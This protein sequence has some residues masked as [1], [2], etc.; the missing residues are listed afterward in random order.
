MKLSTNIPK[1][2]KALTKRVLALGAGIGI[3][4][5]G[6]VMA[7]AA[8][9]QSFNNL[10]DDYATTQVARVGQDYAPSTT[11]N[12]GDTVTVFL[13]DHAT[14]PSADDAH[15]VHLQISLDNGYATSHN[16]LGAVSATN[17]TTASSTAIVNV[18]TTSRITY[19]PDSAKFYRN[20]GGAMTQVN[21]PAGVNPNDIVGA[22]VTVGDQKACWAYA[23]AATIQVH[24]EGGNAAIV[25]NK[26]VELD[27]GQPTFA[28]SA[29]AQPSDVVNFK[30]FLQNTGTA[31]G[32]APYITDT[33]DNR[34]AYIAGSSYTRTKVNNADVDQ[35]YADSNIAING[36]TMTWKFAD[37]LPRPD[38]S[39]YLLFRA[40]VA[41]PAS[42]PVGVTN[43]PNCALSGFTGVSAN[44]NCVN[45][46]VT[47]SADKVVSFSIRKEV[48]N[49]TKG[50]GQWFNAGH[51]GVAA[52]GD[53]LGYRLIVINTGNTPA[54]NVT[55]KDILPAGIAFA[56]NMKT[57]DQDHTSGVD[58]A[59]SDLVNNGYVYST[60]TNGTSE[61]KSI[62][63]TGKVADVCNGDQ[64]LKNV[65]QVIYNGQVQ[66]QDFASVN[67]SCSHSLVI[68]KEIQDPATHEWKKDIGTVHEG[69]IL[70]YRIQ[71]QNNGNATTTN[72]IVR[73]VLPQQVAFVNNS[74]SIDG[75]F[76][77]DQNVQNAFMHDGMLITNLKP[78]GGKLMMFQ[79]KVNECPP[80]GNIAI[81]NA[82][83][84][85]ADGI[86]ELTSTADATIIVRKPTFN[87]H[88]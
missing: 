30:I 47:R 62:T 3:M 61:Y 4:A 64:T 68:T 38:A 82:G 79:V 87:F 7:T 48:T 15:Q 69:D 50:D 86:A 51:S 22:G 71:V 10:P 8:S 19:V 74:L 52:A 14:E 59:S 27:G 70:T 24:I 43:V 35:A 88:L 58:V 20:V 1:A 44:T 23:Q 42:F 11:A 21:W 54:K 56:G 5:S 29:S 32:V 33:L 85:K 39:V 12:V 75:E 77:L 80:L 78:G 81:R 57:Y 67:E 72:T 13:W 65:A 17:A 55:I 25:T 49:L 40:R 2:W 46:A 16:I 6:A 63:F 76:M 53:L 66:V 18:N 34:F 9:P 36:Q 41:A 73:D 84:A 31:T 83:F 45:V 37:M 28:N 60:I 26:T